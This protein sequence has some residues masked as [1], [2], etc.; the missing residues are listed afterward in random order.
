MGGRG[1]E[2]ECGLVGLV[3]KSLDSLEALDALDALE[4]TLEARA[5]LLVKVETSSS[6]SM[7]S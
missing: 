3:L 7:G 2:V 1:G 5:L 6:G 4:V